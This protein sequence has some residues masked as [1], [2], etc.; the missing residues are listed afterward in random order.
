M[1]L[2]LHILLPGDHSISA[3]IEGDNVP[4]GDLFVEIREC[5][6]CGKPFQP[7]REHHWFH[8]VECKNKFHNLNRAESGVRLELHG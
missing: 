7:E 2:R 5:R 1:P 4:E 8:T 6:F 3:A